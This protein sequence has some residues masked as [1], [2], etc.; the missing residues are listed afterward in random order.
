MAT[1]HFTLGEDLGIQLAEISKEHILDYDL[2]KA[3]SLW[4]ESF[5]CSEDMAEELTGGKLVVVVDDPEQCLINVTERESLSKKREKQYPRITKEEIYRLIDKNFQSPRDYDEEHVFYD[6]R[7][8]I[9]EAN[10]IIATNNALDIDARIAGEFCQLFPDWFPK[11][12]TIYGT[13]TVHPRVIVHEMFN[14]KDSEEYL[15]KFEDFLDDITDLSGWRNTDSRKVHLLMW[16]LRL[17]KRII[18]MEPKFMELEDF[19]IKHLNGDPHHKYSTEKHI[20]EVKEIFQTWH[21]WCCANDTGQL[22]MVNEEQ[23]K[24]LN[25]E[26]DQ[27]FNGIKNIDKMSKDFHPVEIT[28]GYDAGWLAPDGKYFGLNG[29][30]GNFLHIAIADNLMDYYGFKKPDDFD[31]SVD[32]F[33]A[34]QGFVKI[35]HDWILYE[36][37]DCIMTDKPVELTRAQIRAIIEYGNKVYGGKLSFGYDKKRKNMEEFELMDQEELADLLGV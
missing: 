16:I 3:I 37:Y 1:V 5:G 9:S 4:I 20:E 18:E 13:M 15:N 21:V 19:A 35:H 26:F 34:K 31:F 8:R 14:A 24:E 29:S 27:Y 28:D 22:T 33:I 30:S 25:S 17:C 10:R 6:L 23:E 2:H 11:G 7:G 36:G 12:V 32:A